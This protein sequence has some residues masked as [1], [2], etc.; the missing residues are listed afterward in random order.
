MSDIAQQALAALM[1]P[2]NDVPALFRPGPFDIAK[3]AVVAELGLFAAFPVFGMP[4][5][6]RSF[7][8]EVGDTAFGYLAASLVS[9]M[10]R[11]M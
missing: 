6:S 11:M 8:A 9:F 10:V 7:M 2:V 3:I 4:L 1:W 5:K